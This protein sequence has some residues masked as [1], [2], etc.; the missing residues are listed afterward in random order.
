MNPIE[1]NNL[2]KKFEIEIAHLATLKADAFAE[3]FKK[4]TARSI[5]EYERL[6]AKLDGV[7]LCRHLLLDSQTVEAY[8]ERTDKDLNQQSIDILSS[9]RTE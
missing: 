5:H 1:K 8:Q 3:S 6:S 9:H 4:Q 2:L 7:F